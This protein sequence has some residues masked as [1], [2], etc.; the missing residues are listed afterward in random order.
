MRRDVRFWP[1]ADMPLTLT[2]GKQFASGEK[3]WRRN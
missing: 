3:R 2:F 1:K